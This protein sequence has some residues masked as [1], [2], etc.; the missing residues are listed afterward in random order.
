M[1]SWDTW[2]HWN[3]VR[4][5]AQGLARLTLKERKGITSSSRSHE[6]VDTSH[7][8]DNSP[9]CHLTPKCLQYVARMIGRGLLAVSGPQCHSVPSPFKDTVSMC[10]LGV[11]ELAMLTRLLSNSQRSTCLCLPSAGV[12]GVCHHAWP[13]V[14]PLDTVYSIV[15]HLCPCLPVWAW[16]PLDPFLN[17]DPVFSVSPSVVQLQ[18]RRCDHSGFS[19]LV[20]HQ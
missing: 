3:P 5:Q 15:I 8:D 13:S 12:K 20:C 7:C 11:T 14:P 17:L 16:P 19:S 9:S 6:K 10:L 4:K 18:S 2:E 1:V